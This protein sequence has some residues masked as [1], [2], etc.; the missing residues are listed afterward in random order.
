MKKAVDTTTI[1][2]RIKAKRVEAGLSQEKLSDF[3]RKIRKPSYFTSCQGYPVGG[4][5]F[6]TTFM[7]DGVE[8]SMPPM[9]KTARLNME[10]AVQIWQNTTYIIILILNTVSYI[11]LLYKK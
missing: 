4:D 7:K 1:G 5:F 6:M 8:I 11:I 2:G 3:I 10:R 9:D